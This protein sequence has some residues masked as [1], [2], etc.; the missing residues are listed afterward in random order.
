MNKSFSVHRIHIDKK[1][2]N[3]YVKLTG[4]LHPCSP[5]GKEIQQRQDYSRN[6]HVCWK[7]LVSLFTLISVKCERT[8]FI[9]VNSENNNNN[10][11]DDDDNNND[12][13]NVF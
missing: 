9:I 12:N 11:D 4:F 7:C 3:L 13:N 5:S 10:D 8:H 6:R 1:I 2:E